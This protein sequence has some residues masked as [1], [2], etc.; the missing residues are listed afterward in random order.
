MATETKTPKVRYD[1]LVAHEYTVGDDKRTA[2][3]KIGAA[4]PTQD[5]KGFNLEIT[6]NISVSGRVVLRQYEPKPAASE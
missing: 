4:F 2:W 1:A 3:T 6:P 5:G